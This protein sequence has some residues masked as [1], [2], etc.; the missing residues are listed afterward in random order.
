VE[1]PDATIELLPDKLAGNDS[2]FGR[3]FMMY[4]PD[5]SKEISISSRS[6]KRFVFSKT[7]SPMEL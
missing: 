5:A 2:V 3:C 6:M 4:N 1:T 7:F